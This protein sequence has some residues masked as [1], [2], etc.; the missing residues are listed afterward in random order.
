MITI[1][2]GT[3]ILSSAPRASAQMGTDPGFSL[4][5]VQCQE[6]AFGT[7]FIFSVGTNVPPIP[8]MCRDTA[9][10]S[11][12]FGE[13]FANIQGACSSGL[14][15]D[16]VEMDVTW[17]LCT[18]PLVG[19]SVGGFGTRIVTSIGVCG[20]TFNVAGQVFGRARAID[21]LLGKVLAEGQEGFADCVDN[22]SPAIPP[23][24]SHC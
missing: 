3:L 8:D 4:D 13:A 10:P 2:F 18:T 12:I 17:A 24:I 6:G 15:T 19:E 20:P 7:P 9:G 16:N 22:T 14:L 5:F 11:T 23:A 1:L 21:F